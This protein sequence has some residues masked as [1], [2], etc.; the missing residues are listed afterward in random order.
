MKIRRIVDE[1]LLEEVRRLPCLAH[2][3]QDPRV[4]LEAIGEGVTRSH[5]HHVVSRGAGGDDV[6]S[7]VMPL[8]PAC[9]QEVHTIGM[10]A[11]REKYPII[12]AWMAAVEAER[13]A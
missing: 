8:C 13:G 12:D 3:C 10:R 1:S 4:A 2:A 7:N 5:P 9:H 6:A 11:M